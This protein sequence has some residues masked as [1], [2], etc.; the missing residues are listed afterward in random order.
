MY[1]ILIY[2][3]L[4]MRVTATLMILRTNFTA[5]APEHL[6]ITDTTPAIPHRVYLPVQCHGRGVDSLQNLLCSDYN[7]DEIDQ[8]DHDS[9]FTISVTAALRDRCDEAIPVIMAEL[10]QMLDK[11]FGTVCTRET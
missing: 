5:A 10:K 8:D 4:T 2:N 6:K 9:A 11:Q 7:D 1:M 3:Q